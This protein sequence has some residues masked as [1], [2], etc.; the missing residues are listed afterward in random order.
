MVKAHE[1]EIPNDSKEWRI[2]CRY[3]R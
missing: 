2:H 3:H 1:G